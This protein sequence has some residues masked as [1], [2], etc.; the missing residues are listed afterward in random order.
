MLEKDRNMEIPAKQKMERQ[1][2]LAREHSEE[3]KAAIQR[4]VALDIPHAYPSSPY[5]TFCEME[6]GDNERLS[7]ESS[8]LSFKKRRESWDG[9]V[10]RLFDV[11]EYG[12]MVF[13]KS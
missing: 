5:G 6:E 9:L 13:K 3:Y 10:E 8:S 7:G 2:S 1:E 11:D 12:E 4:A